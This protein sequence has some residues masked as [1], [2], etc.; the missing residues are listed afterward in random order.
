M[1]VLDTTLLVFINIAEIG[2]CMTLFCYC[3]KSGQTNL[4]FLHVAA[5]WC[6][7]VYAGSASGTPASSCDN[8]H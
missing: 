3:G 5:C 6:G 8:R 7:F 1:F 2:G 4:I